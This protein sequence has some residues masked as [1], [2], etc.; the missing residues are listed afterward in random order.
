[1]TGHHEHFTKIFALMGFF[2]LKYGNCIQVESSNLNETDKQCGGSFSGYQYSISSPNYPGNYPAKLDCTYELRG[3]QFSKCDQEFHLQYLDFNLKPSENCEKDFLKV[4]DHDVLCGNVVGIRQFKGLNNSLRL[5]FHSDEER[6]GRGFK[7]LVTT[8]PCSSVK[9]DP[10]RSRS[11]T[12]SS[13]T[14][15][16]SFSLDGAAE[17]QFNTDNENETLNVPASTT[18]FIFATKESLTNDFAREELSPKIGEENVYSMYSPNIEFNV[19]DIEGGRADQIPV[20]IQTSDSN[21]KKN[22]IFTK[23]H[24]L[25]TLVV[26]KPSES[27]QLP[28]YEQH[29]FHDENCQHFNI[30]ENENPLENPFETT[31]NFAS[32]QENHK[33]HI[34][35][36]LYLPPS[37]TVP[38]KI[39]NQIDENSSNLTDSVA[40][41]TSSSLAPPVIFQ[42]IPFSTLSNVASVTVPPTEILLPN[43]NTVPK[44]TTLVNAGNRN[45]AE[46]RQSPRVSV[47]STSNNGIDGVTRLINEGSKVGQKYI[48]P[49]TVYGTP[50][51]AN[52]NINKDSYY[53]PS[54]INYPNANNNPSTGGVNCNGNISP[55]FP[56]INTGFNTGNVNTNYDPLANNVPNT[57]F[58][59]NTNFD[60]N[61]NPGTNYIPSTINYPNTN[62]DV[63][64][65]F[66][67]S[68]NYPSINLNPDNNFDFSFGVNSNYPGTNFGVGSN[69]N[70]NTGFVNSNYYPSTGTVNTNYDPNIGIVNTNYYPSTGTNVNGQSS[71]CCNTVYSSQRFLLTSPGFPALTYSSKSYECRYTIRKYSQDVCQ[72]R[73]N[74]KFFYLGS[75]DQFC[76]YGYLDIDGQRVCGCKS[77][78][79]IVSRFSNYATKTIT[80][81]YLGYPRIKFNGFLIEVIQESCSNS[82]ARALKDIEQSRTIVNSRLKR[83]STGYFYEKPSYSLPTTGRHPLQNPGSQ[84]NQNLFFNSCQA[85]V[86]FNWAVA[87]KTVYLRNAQCSTTGSSSLISQVIP[88][89]PVSGSWISYPAANCEGI[90]VIDGTISSPQY[91]RNYPEN[92]NKCYRFYKAPGYCQLELAIL[93]FDLENTKGCYKDY[94]SFSGQ[95]RRYCGTSL[96]GSR[97]IFDTSR[98]NIVDM[99][100]VS[101]SSGSGRGFR[102]GFTQISCQ[103]QD[104]HYHKENQTNNS[105]QENTECILERRSKEGIELAP[106]LEPRS[107]KNLSCSYVFLKKHGYCMLRLH[108]EEFELIDS[109]GCVMGYLAIRGRRFCGRFLEGKVL[110]LPFESISRTVELPYFMK[111][112]VDFVKWRFTYKY[113]PCRSTMVHKNKKW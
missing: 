100:F 95:N 112:D 3:S 68:G 23:T 76:A 104:I 1:M 89:F 83:S 87:A 30:H 34:T 54:S 36:Y 31:A 51:E 110:D 61:N 17:H 26:A 52:V 93:D 13:T 96:A 107:P 97:A 85:L 12:E 37:S 65:N 99:Y 8:L 19:E 2:I 66:G 5:V 50:G 74:F 18:Q 113:L 59:V 67:V 21:I 22:S 46:F 20:K 41:K 15:E 28:I 4:G 64:T 91:P 9:I 29:H 92:L 88:I 27:F 56:N 38:L 71:E 62:F 42:T 81:K 33:P 60:F 90:N 80:L 53:I 32:T 86:F 57:N 78:T 69:Y 111:N 25:P 44:F 11:V 109:P 72:L 39:R 6:G 43:F 14:S 58:G 105:Q 7:I 77:S 98:S 103:G 48:T 101:D 73:L 102:V 35:S 45:L 55:N 84:T 16:N 79:S 24:N 82:Y 40:G 47:N 108:F 49:A 106:S 63:N 10:K 70:P 94:V 75:D